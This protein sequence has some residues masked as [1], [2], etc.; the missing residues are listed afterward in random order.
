MAPDIAQALK[1]FALIAAALVV[2][3]WKTGKLFQAPNFL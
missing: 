1:A 3:S 2:W